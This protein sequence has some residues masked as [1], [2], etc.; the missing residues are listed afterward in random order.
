MSSIMRRRNGLMASLVMGMLLSWVKVANPSSQDRTPRHAI[1][2]AVPPAAASLPRERFSPLTLSGL[3]SPQMNGLD[4]FNIVRLLLIRILM[5]RILLNG[6]AAR[7]NP[8]ESAGLAA[9]HRDR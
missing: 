5:I 7:E 4:S 9:I 1:P 6:E 8:V 2:S 3:F